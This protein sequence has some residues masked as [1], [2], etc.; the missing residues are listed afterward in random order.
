MNVTLASWRSGTTL[1][2]VLAALLAALCSVCGVVSAVERDFDGDLRADILWRHM[3]AGGTGE[4]YFHPLNGTTILAGEG[5]LRTVSDMS[6]EM[7]GF[8]DFDGDGRS[9]VLWRNQ[10][11]GENYIYFMNGKAI[12][13]EGFIRTVADLNWKVVGVGD[14]DG[15]LRADILWRNSSNG[16]NYIYAMNGTTIAS[17]GSIRT[18]AD[19]NWQVAGVGNFDGNSTADVLWRNRATGDNYIYFLNGKTIAAEGYVRTVADLNWKVAGVGD[20]DGDGRSDILWRNG[21]SGENYVYPMQGLTIKPSEGYIRTV[22]DQNWQ[23]AAVSNFD[24]NAAPATADILWRNLSTGENYLYPMNG[25]A[26]LPGEG[27][28]RTVPDRDW[29]VQPAGACPTV[30]NGAIALSAV[31]SRTSGVAP[32]YVFFD[33]AGTTAT[34]TTRPFHELEYHWNFGDEGNGLWTATPEMQNLRRNVATGPVAAHVY[35]KPGTYTACVTVFDGAN[36]VSRSI[37][38]TVTDADTVF[39]A[40]TLC[41][42]NS[43]PVAGSGGCPAGAAV[44]Q[45]SNFTAAINNNIASRKRIL[46]RRGDTFTSSASANIRVNGPGLIGAFGTGAAPRVNVT[47]NNRAFELSS[48]STPG[49]KDWRIMDLEINGNSGA[50]TNGVYAEGGIDQVTL[51][52]LNIHHVHF[53]VQLS[54]FVLDYYG[55]QHR[56]WDQV[57]VVDSSIQTIVGGGGG[58]GLYVGAQRFALMGNVLKDSTQAEHILRTPNIVKA[59]ISHN[60]MANSAPTKHVVKL[61]AAVFNVSPTGFSEQIVMSDNKFTGGAGVDWTV[62]IGPENAQSDEKVKHVIVER[63]WFAPH[64]AQDQALTVWAQ[65]V[66]VR[67]NLFNLTG[68]AGRVG[69][70]VE[71][72]GVEPPPASVHA[73]NNTFYSNSAGGFFPIRFATGAGMIAKN[74]L[75]YAPLS[76]SR[77]MISGS[78]IIENNT[79]NAGI[80]VSPGFLSPTPAVPADFLLGVASSDIDAGA[81][82]PVFSDLLRRKRPMSRAVDR[83]AHERP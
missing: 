7:V 22:A 55:G 42:G 78:A 72:R 34:A 14:F 66:T 57:A 10:V 3:G 54:P 15:D 52:R 51:L 13:A 53:G 63:N 40:N 35:E 24:G 56:L 73:Y 71:R 29:K 61:Q 5:Y 68:T 33:T 30:T 50:A 62:A 38:I 25:T 80:L 8:G 49:I 70:V 76:T 59:V 2:G 44:L 83:G 39:A 47:G 41:V 45:S 1:R 77:D 46:F 64:S 11:T 12:I 26:V 20:F 79:T 81:A 21:S 4:N 16:E 23:V 69:I 32:L 18:V 31:P 28:L 65:D 82:V 75:G 60:D 58:Y 48:G 6:W 19:Q 67:N 17:E 37:Q 27:Y 43:L 74:N 9:D 36:T